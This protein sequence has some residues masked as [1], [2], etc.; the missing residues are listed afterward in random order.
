M[1]ICEKKKN[2]KISKS[3]SNIKFRCG[4]SFRFR[5]S[6]KFYNMIFFEQVYVYDE[7]LCNL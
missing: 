2:Y 6:F 4:F 1:K 7:Q 3:E 5:F